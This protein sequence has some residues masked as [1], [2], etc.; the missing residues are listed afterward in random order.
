[1]RLNFP[2]HRGGA[3]TNRQV[4]SSDN[5]RQ[6][7]KSKKQSRKTKQADET[8]RELA[9]PGV[10]EFS[11]PR[12]RQ[13][14]STRRP[15]IWGRKGINDSETSR[16]LP[17]QEK[18]KKSKE[19]NTEER[20]KLMFRQSSRQVLHCKTMVNPLCGRVLESEKSVTLAGGVQNAV[21]GLSR[22]TVGKRQLKSPR[23]DPGRV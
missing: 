15:S 17:Q 7:G 4:K 19:V 16:L 1:M 22:D 6:G 10:R 11:S 23:S 18:K 9:S 8:G 2:I 20:G 5:L 3:R 14:K 13:G 12:S 21:T